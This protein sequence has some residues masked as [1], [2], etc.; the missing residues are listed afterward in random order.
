M[1]LYR[2]AGGPEYAD[3]AASFVMARPQPG[4]ELSLRRRGGGHVN[5]VTTKRIKISLFSL[6]LKER[7]R[8]EGDLWDKFIRFS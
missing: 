8:A 6:S 4:G 1:R 3:V 5:Q 2:A 7:H